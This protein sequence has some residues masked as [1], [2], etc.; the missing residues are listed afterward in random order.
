M[1]RN[2]ERN[3]WSAVVLSAL[4]DFN[5]D[6]CR[7]VRQGEDTAPVLADVRMYFSSRDGR[8]VC[9]CA[10]LHIGPDQAVAAIAM[11][12]RD[13][14]ARQLHDGGSNPELRAAE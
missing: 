6:Y 14:K 3:M 1:T 5:L 12:R 10:G 8:T 4:D 7:A 13:F 2:P 11:P 9:A